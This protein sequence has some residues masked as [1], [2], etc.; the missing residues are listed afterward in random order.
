[1]QV[2]DIAP[3]VAGPMAGDGD[4]E[5]FLAGPPVVLDP[6]ALLRRRPPIRPASALLIFFLRLGMVVILL[7]RART[8]R[9]GR[10][11][12]MGMVKRAGQLTQGFR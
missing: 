6:V 9:D 3:L 5:S 2:A 10:D 12:P 4:H 8:A 11:G 7:S 1:M